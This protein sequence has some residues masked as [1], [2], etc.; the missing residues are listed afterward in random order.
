M[1]FEKYKY[2]IAAGIV[3]II[4]SL[5]LYFLLSKKSEPKDPN[6]GEGFIFSFSSSY[7][8]DSLNIV[9]PAS[10]GLSTMPSGISLLASNTGDKWSVLY[11]NNSINWNTGSNIFKINSTKPYS[12]FAVVITSLSNSNNGWV[13]QSE[14][15]F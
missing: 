10:G 5:I 13:V 15:Y 8:V 11:K 9:S 4:V 12:L 6:D 3:I 7:L 14:G 2:Y 1:N